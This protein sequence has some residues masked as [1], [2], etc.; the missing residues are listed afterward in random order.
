MHLN[1]FSLKRFFK[2]TEMAKNTEIVAVF[3]VQ[4][5]YLADPKPEYG[6][7][8]YCRLGT[9]SRHAPELFLVSKDFLN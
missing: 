6:P 5:I 9:A 3:I 4:V 2:L 1:H 7:Q 8:Y